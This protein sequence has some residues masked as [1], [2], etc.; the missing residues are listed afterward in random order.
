MLNLGG[1]RIYGDL[2]LISGS[3]NPEL[4]Q[5]I[6]D[7]LG[8]PLLKR[9]I[10]TFPNDNIFVQLEETVR[11]RDVFIIQPTCRPVNYNLMELLILIHTA[12][13]ASA[14]RIT[15][16]MPFYAYARSDKKDMPR[17]PI[18]AKLVADLIQTAGADRF[19]CVD[20]HAGQ[21]QG[22]FDMPGD[23]LTAFPLAGAACAAHGHPRSG[24]AARLISALPKRRATLPRCCMRRWPLSKSDARAPAPRACA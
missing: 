13:R 3:G 7:A 17:V 18:T 24:G 12:R 4:A 23:E 20:L 8:Q 19:M 10:K 16:V 5:E 11:S 14:G 22:F 1:T 15:A 6:A 9:T 2:A 21:I